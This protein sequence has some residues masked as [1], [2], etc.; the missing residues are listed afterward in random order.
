M[1]LVFLVP[2]TAA[3]CSCEPT[4]NILELN[5]ADAQTLIFIGAVDALDGADKSKYFFTQD[6]LLGVRPFLFLRGSWP[7]RP[8]ELW[9]GSVDG[10][11]DCGAHLQTGWTYLLVT[12]RTDDG[13]L[14][15]GQC[16]MTAPLVGYG[17]LVGLLAA[18]M[19]ATGAIAWG[20][21]RW[22]RRVLSPQ[23]HTAG[24][25]HATAWTRSPVAWLFA[26]GGLLAMAVLFWNLA[27][28]LPLSSEAT[29]CNRVASEPLEQ[30]EARLLPESPE[31]PPA[32][33]GR[34]LP[35]EC[36]TVP[37]PWKGVTSL[38]LS[39]QLQGISFTEQDE[40]LAS[41]E[42]G[43]HTITEV[44]APGQSVS[45]R[46]VYEPDLRMFALALGILACIS[47]TLATLCCAAWVA[48]R[49]WRR[50]RAYANPT[51]S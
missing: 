47:G 4:R 17:M 14:G 34:L 21:W 42:R 51:A 20:P 46:D 30:V 10:S 19:L 1:L 11:G 7:E 2:A 27:P 15:A 8:V 18:L 9:A 37:L 33:L 45:W 31:R 3:A 16:S 49:T 5:L 13:R 25:R 12:R 48:F 43:R 23:E 39:Y 38:S 28:R 26:S 35:G 50:A 24:G 44:R 6:R 32:Q 41:I 22:L 40:A 36:R 29:V